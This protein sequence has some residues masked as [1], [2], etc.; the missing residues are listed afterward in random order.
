MVLFLIGL[1]LIWGK[2]MTCLVF[3]CL[4][5]QEYRVIDIKHK[6]QIISKCD[7]ALL[8][9]YFEKVKQGE[10]CCGKRV[11]NRNGNIT[12]TRRKRTD[13]ILFAA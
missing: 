12:H 11:G 8:S 10:D 13:V 7:L 3:I 9:F 1:V 6:I 5:I 4:N 2:L